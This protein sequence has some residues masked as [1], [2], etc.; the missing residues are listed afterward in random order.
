MAANSLRLASEC[1]PAIRYDV[2]D[3]SWPASS[4]HFVQTTCNT[5][6]VIAVCVDPIKPS[7]FKHGVAVSEPDRRR[8]RLVALR[9]GGCHS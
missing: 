9:C 7:A 1:R 8:V 5:L 6:R 2:L 3:E 4:I